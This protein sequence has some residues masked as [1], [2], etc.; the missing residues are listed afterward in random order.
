MSRLRDEFGILPRWYVFAVFLV[1]GSRATLIAAVADEPA[2]ERLVIASVVGTLVLIYLLLVGYVY[3]DAK[4]RGMRQIAW[5][6]IVIFVPSAIGFIVYFLLR[7]PVLTPCGTCGSP[8]RR[9]FAFC[10]DCGATLRRACPDCQRPVEP[11][12]AH[13]AACG[14]TLIDAGSRPSV[15]PPASE[16]EPG[17]EPELGDAAPDADA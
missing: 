3:A 10:P 13:C 1:V 17:P 15:P 11:F 4:R 16:P 9:E 5:T 7:E 12:W 8:A 14:S 6:L 2:P